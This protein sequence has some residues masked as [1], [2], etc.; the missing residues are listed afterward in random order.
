MPLRSAFAVVAVSGLATAAEQPVVEVSPDGHQTV[1]VVPSFTDNT[2]WAIESAVPYP[3]QPD[4]SIALRR[5]IGGLAIGDLNGDGFNDIAAVCYTSQ[6]FPPY[7]QFQD[8]VYFGGPNGI[9]TTP[10]YLT[11]L[12]TH[13]GDVQLGDIN[14]DGRL[15]M[16]TVHGGGIR[17][18]HLRVY[19]GSASGLPTT[20]SWVSTWGTRGWGTSAVI[21]D[22]DN[23]DDLD[24]FTTNQ[25]LSPD[26]FRPMALYRNLGSGLAT[27]PSWQSNEA[28]I[29]GGASAGDFDGDGDMDIGV[30]KWVNFES[31]IYETVGG[32]PTEP[33]YFET[34]TILDDPDL[35]D[36][37]DR[38]S[39]FADIDGDGQL[40]FLV[41]GD[42]SRLYTQDNGVF[43]QSWAAN[44]PFAGPQDFK[45]FDVDG[46]G[47][48]DVAEIHFS[49]GR[50]HI[51]L[52][53]NGVLSTTPSWTY[54]ASEV[55]TAIAFGDLNGDNLP[56]LVT[57]Y[58]GNTSI[59]IFYAQSQNCNAADLAEPF[60]QLTFADITAFLAAFNASDPA[61][62]L[63]DPQG[64]FTFADITAFLAA[65]NAGCP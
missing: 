40:D 11:T 37:T 6:S 2:G 62:D 39:A 43:T 4:V 12:A 56:D 54:D 64:Q 26:P 22:I 46:D 5:Q 14:G 52:N 16:V 36:E 57:G 60:G 34:N 23:D 35:L 41:G 18:D 53:D 45:T 20:A 38:G 9:E 59:R 49:D 24:V 44:P 21:V 42:P 30:S 65:F 3:T 50:A 1:E 48:Q 19:Y 10:S 61:A 25:G 15:D 31:A 47:D 27:V 63:A 28:S 32:L 33:P 13:A 8:Q 55:G 58:S 17:A 29:Q 7:D 51:Y